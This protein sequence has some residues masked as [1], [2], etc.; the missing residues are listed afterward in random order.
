MK[1]FKSVSLSA[2]TSAFA[3]TASADSGTWIQ[4]TISEIQVVAHGSGGANEVRVFGAFSP[5]LGCTKSAFALFSTDQYFNQ[6]YAAIL[7]A[8]ARG[9]P[10][11]VLFVYCMETGYARANGYSALTN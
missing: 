2:L 3:L 1:K 7:A 10:I 4:G 11:K 5:S 6:S 8:Q 9:T